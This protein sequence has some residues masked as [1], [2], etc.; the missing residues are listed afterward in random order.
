MEIRKYASRSIGRVWDLSEVSRGKGFCETAA[1]GAAPPDPVF[2]DS[3]GAS[4]S[5]FV[6]VELEL[7]VA[8]EARL[9]KS[10][11]SRV[12]KSQI[13]KSLSDDPVTSTSSSGMTSRVLMKS[14]C[15]IVVDM[16]V[17]VWID[18]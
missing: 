15:A 13:R 6:V 2:F 18:E 12:D 4:D 8:E 17:L 9:E 7:A 5:S 16:A 14:V 11:E 3:T 10:K 1:G